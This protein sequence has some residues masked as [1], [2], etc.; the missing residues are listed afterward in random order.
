MTT[1]TANLI[2]FENGIAFQSDTGMLIGWYAN[3]S[4]I[5][6]LDIVSRLRVFAQP[7]IYLPR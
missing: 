4:D 3:W 7:G 1:R 2:V 5:L 6:K